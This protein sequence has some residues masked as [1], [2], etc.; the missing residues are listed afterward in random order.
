MAT[1]DAPVRATQTTI[2]VIRALRELDSAGV[3][4]VAEH[5]DVPTSTAFDHL[6]TL[7]QNE[8]VR[9]EGNEYVLGSQFLE[10]G[11]YC[12]SNDH[13]YRI[14]EP[15]IQKMAHKTGEHANLMIEEFGKGVFYAKAEGE[16][17]FQLDTHV[18]KRVHL[19][20]TGAGKA[21]LA[22]LPDEEVEGIIDTHGLPRIT[23]QTITD[24]ETLFEE[25][26]AVRDQGFATE[27]EERIQGVR[28]VGAALTDGDGDVLG[29][30][31]VSGPKSGMQDE[32]FFEDI[33]E[34]VLR[35]ANVIEVNM[36][37]Q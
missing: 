31:S 29:A 26:D 34:L 23:D 35:T 9:R 16:D 3:S 27:T 21:I 28:C 6:R 1:D 18:G 22:E 11:G 12:R 8:F 19:Q 7:E 15:E 10:I 33:P 30:V 24:R 4:A 13:L 14:A 5:L 25:L 36:K 17:A 20:T 32:R 37:Y 2:R